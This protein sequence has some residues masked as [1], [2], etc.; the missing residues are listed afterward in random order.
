MMASHTT[1]RSA[2]P[3]GLFLFAA[4]L[5]LVPVPSLEAEVLRP[6]ASETTAAGHLLDPGETDVVR[7]RELEARAWS[8]R[9]QMNRRGQAGRLLREAAE[10]RPADDPAKVS[11]LR[12]ASRMSFHAGNF[13]QAATDAG[14]AAKAALRQG[15]VL[16]AAHA[17]LDAAWMAVEAGESGRALAFAE[18]AMILTA[19]PLLDDED[20][21]GIMGRVTAGA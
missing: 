6:A 19:S 7:A 16:Q 17:Y 8:L 10:L 9:D 18:E 12:D 1:L 3:A 20:R 11:N 21:E 5:L 4:A 14:E 2:P 13:A 15:D